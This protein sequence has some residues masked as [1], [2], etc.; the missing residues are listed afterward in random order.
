M[1]HTA[2]AD[3]AAGIG[4]KA[5]ENH[6]ALDARTEFDKSFGDTHGKYLSFSHRIRIV[7]LCLAFA[8]LNVAYSLRNLI[9]PA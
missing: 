9:L 5:L 7:I 1:S 4:G 3:L 2:C 8:V 6:I